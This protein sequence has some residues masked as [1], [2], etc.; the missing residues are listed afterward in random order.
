LMHISQLSPEGVCVD[1]SRKQRSRGL[2]I[3]IDA[4]FATFA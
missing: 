4:H 1:N 3:A 2:E